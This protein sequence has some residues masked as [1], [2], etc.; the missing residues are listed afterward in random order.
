MD[1]FAQALAACGVAEDEDRTV[2][3]QRWR[4]RGPPEWLRLG[5]TVSMAHLPMPSAL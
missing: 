1:H 4:L 2:E 3:S 5:R